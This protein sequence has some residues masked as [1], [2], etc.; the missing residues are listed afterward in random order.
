MKRFCCYLLVLIFLSGCSTAPQPKSLF[1]Q[2]QKPPKTTKEASSKTKPSTEDN[3]S[4]LH[5]MAEEELK[6]YTKKYGVIFAKTDFQGVLQTSYV[7]LLFEN[8]QHPE[9]RFQLHIGD[10]SRNPFPWDVTAVQP[11]YFFIEL[12]AGEYKI[13]SLSIPVGSTTASEP[14]DI[15]LKVI[16]DAITYIGTL[17]VV[18]TKET[19]KLGVVP[20]FKPGFEYSASVIDERQ[21]AVA[22]FRQQYPNIQNEISVHLMRVK[23]L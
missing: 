23:S 22:V 4:D 10:K 19:I 9:N 5:N 14:V 1:T 16:E 21:E 17:K 3:A 15:K 12:P 6:E 20:V 13:S 18:G 7:R 11:G 8:V 2:K